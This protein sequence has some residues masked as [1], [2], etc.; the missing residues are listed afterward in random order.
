MLQ[1]AFMK[2]IGLLKKY[3][4]TYDILIFPDQLKHTIDFVK[5]FPGQAFVIDH[6]AKPY[7]KDKLVNEWKKDI[8]AI[9]EYENVYCKI[10]GMVTEADWKQWKK[11]D[12]SPY[13]EVVIKAFGTNRVMYGSD[14]PVCLVAASYEKV[15]ETVQDHFA[16][17]SPNEQ[18]LFFGGNAIKF[19]NLN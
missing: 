18:E 16:S 5:A 11:S 7:I 17:Y 13:L 1:P 19:Y 8:E 6:V 2:G 14:W 9:A 15:V 10:S 4:F 3:N 12:I